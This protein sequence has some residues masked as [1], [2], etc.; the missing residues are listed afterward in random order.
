MRRWGTAPSLCSLQLTLILAQASVNLSNSFCP[1][2]L[3]PMPLLLAVHSA[4]PIVPL[5]RRFGALLAALKHAL[6]LR[7]Q[8]QRQRQRQRLPYCLL[9]LQWW[10][11][12][13]RVVSVRCG[14]NSH[15]WREMMEINQL[16][17]DKKKRGDLLGLLDFIGRLALADVLVCADLA[18]RVVLASISLRPGSRRPLR[19]RSLRSR[20][21]P[22][23]EVLAVAA[24]LVRPGAERVPAALRH[25]RG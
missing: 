6:V 24:V 12:V 3:L 17:E 21:S 4:E 18:V 16:D 7:L 5:C 20:S 25:E 23:L 11:W 14:I 10:T 19:S 15:R 1:L 8:R 13:I 22:D 2:C 9:P